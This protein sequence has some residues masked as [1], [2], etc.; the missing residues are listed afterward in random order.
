MPRRCEERIARCTGDGKVT[1]MATREQGK[2]PV[3]GQTPAFVRDDEGN[4]PIREVLDLIGDTWSLLVVMNLQEGPVR[5]NALRRRIEGISQ[6]MLAVTL[7]GLEADGL[8]TR[9]VTPTMP[10]QVEYAL[11]DIGHSLA[12]PVAALGDW[13][14]ANRRAVRERR[15]AY[16]AQ[17]EAA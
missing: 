11:T 10:P 5:F 8:V 13:A 7:R 12:I 15:R 9:T 17:R 1:G 2:A 4:C 3:L 16:A 6:R 14:V